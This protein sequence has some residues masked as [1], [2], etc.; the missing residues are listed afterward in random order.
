MEQVESHSELIHHEA[1]NESTSGSHPEA[2][3]SFTVSDDDILRAQGHEAVFNRSFSIVASLGFA[4]NITN[5]WVGALSN[6]GQNFRYGGSQVALFSVII[7]CFVQWII[8]LGLSEL[9]SAFPSSGSNGTAW[10]LGIINSMYCFGASD[11]A[12]HIAEE[13]QSPSHRLPQIMSAKTCLLE[14]DTSHWSVYSSTTISSLDSCHERHG[15]SNERRNASRGT[16]IPSNRINQGDRGTER[17]LEN[18]SMPSSTVGHLWA[19]C[20]GLRQ[21]SRYSISG[22]IYLVSTSAFNSIITSA[23]TLLNLSYA[24][25][26][27]IAQCLPKRPLDLGRWGY[28]CNVFAPLWIIVLSVMVCFPPDLPV[29]LGSMNYSAPVLVALYLIILVFW[30]LIGDEFKGPDW[31]ILNLKNETPSDASTDIAGPNIDQ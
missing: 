6:V 18:N 15:P 19:S 11:G 3:N 25:P 31:E 2:T 24:I 4:F 8:T 7:A 27:G 5:A 12:I 23:V 30:G 22:L 13:M 26:Q 17:T 14:Y 16:I 20:M 28:I 9:A 1:V 29:T 21:R 10:L